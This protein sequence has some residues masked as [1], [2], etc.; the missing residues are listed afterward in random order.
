MA[1]GKIEGGCRQHTQSSS[2]KKYYIQKQIYSIDYS[3]SSQKRSEREKMQRVSRKAH[4]PICGKPDWC[5]VA[6]DGLAVICAR[7]EDGSVKK[8]GDAGWLHILVDRHKSQRHSLQRSFKVELNNRPDRDFMALQ[9]QY[10]R[11]IKDVQLNDLSQQLGI[12]PYS[13]KR[14]R[15]GWDGQSYTFPMSNDFGK[16]I[17]IRRRFHTGRKVSVKGSKMGLFIPP[18]LATDGLLLICEG[19]T[20]TAAALDLDFAAIGRPNCNSKIEMTV[21]AAQGRKEIVIIGDNDTQGRAGAKKL[22]D[23]LVLHYSNVK[24]IYPPDEINDLRQWLKAGL[25]TK[26][27]LNLIQKTKPI[28][29][30]IDCKD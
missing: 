23:A 4:C 9:E 22:A 5:L 6:K 2:P 8:C 24:V 13:L 18:D 21:K 25:S 14:L 30:R 20:D 11:Q 15:I 26:T 3:G 10:N 29:I 19:P 28:E 16:I 7:I 1:N 17:G 27:L 12:S